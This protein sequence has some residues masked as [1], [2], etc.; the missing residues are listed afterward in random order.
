MNKRK[1]LVKQ[2]FLY[3]VIAAF[4]LYYF[5]IIFCIGL[6]VNPYLALAILFLTF[7]FCLYYMNKLRDSLAENL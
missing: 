7:T 2:F 5:W 6:T 1:L 4:L 3:W